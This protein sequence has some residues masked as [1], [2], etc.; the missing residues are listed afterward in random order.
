MKNTKRQGSVLIIVIA[1]FALAAIGGLVY[2]ALAP[3]LT[4]SPSPT[5][6]VAVATP[7]PTPVDP[8]AS[9]KTY[10]GSKGCDGYSFKYPADWQVATKTNPFSD[11]PDGCDSAILTSPFGNNLNWYSKYYGDGPGCDFGDYNECPQITTTAVSSVN[12]ELQDIKLLKQ[13]IC[14]APEMTACDGVI[15]LGKHPLID[16][17]LTWTVGVERHYPIIVFDSSAF[18]MTSAKVTGYGNPPYLEYA[19]DKAAAQTWLDTAEVK[20]AELIMKSLTK[21]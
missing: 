2:Y 13:V 16:D 18:Y 5:A 3:K 19:S 14:N 9:W 12:S 6:V 7:T 15:A 17:K 20:T 4:P 21:K 11:K 10:A 8:Y 1:A